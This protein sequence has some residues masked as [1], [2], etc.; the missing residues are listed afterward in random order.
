MIA[1][2]AKTK[3]QTLKELKDRLGSIQ[4]EIRDG[5]DTVKSLQAERE[6]LAARSVLDGDSE[7]KGELTHLDSSIE[8]A[9]SHLRN[10]RWASEAL[11]KRIAPAQK[12]ADEERRA[13]FVDRLCDMRT[14][15][16][17]L[18]T[19]LTSDIEDLARH[20]QEVLW[21]QQ[22]ATRALLDEYE[23]N[24]PHQLARSFSIDGFLTSLANCLGSR[25]HR[26]G[27]TDLPRS[28]LTYSLAAHVLSPD[29]IREI[30]NNQEMK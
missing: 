12:E 11:M 4:E 26:L 29:R 18:I 3:A 30:A 1:V 14:Q 28:E 19:F 10:L 27:L 6:N 5:A 25:L 16:Q 22:K 23:G 13:E 8:T 7:A 9:E 17:D 2:P 21:L 24:P 15:E 20:T